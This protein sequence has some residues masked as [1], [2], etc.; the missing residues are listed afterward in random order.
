MDPADALYRLADDLADP[1]GDLVAVAL[2]EASEVRGRGVQHLLQDLAAMVAADV[3][4]RREVEAS[5]APHRTT[6]KGMTVIF[7]VFG[8]LLAWRRDYSAAYGTPLGQLVLAVLLGIC[9]GGLYV[10]YRLA[11]QTPVNRFLTR[12]TASPQVEEP[13]P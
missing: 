10:M 1:V 13:Q 12:P 9:G 7:I 2:I 3:A 4:G 8:V 11:H 5:R 6:V